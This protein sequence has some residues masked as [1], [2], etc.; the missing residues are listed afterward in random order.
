MQKRVNFHEQADLET[1]PVNPRLEIYYHT[2]QSNEC[3]PTVFAETHPVKKELESTGAMAM[4]PSSFYLD[5]K[6]DQWTGSFSI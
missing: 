1:I 4:R 3:D 6:N 5:Y 2:V